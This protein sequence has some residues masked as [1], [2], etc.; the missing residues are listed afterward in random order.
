MSSVNYC[1]FPLFRAASV[2]SVLAGVFFSGETRLSGGQE[3][4][5]DA[6]FFA[7]LD[8]DREGLG[9]VRRAVRSGDH[10]EARAELADYFRNREG[11]FHPIDPRA[12]TKGIANA[13]RKLRAGRLLVDRTGSWDAELWS[14]GEFDWERAEIRFKERMYFFESLAEA[15][16]LEES[17]EIARELVN[18][19]RSFAHRYH[20][21]EERGGGMW[22]TMNVGIR[23]RTG[24]PAA[25]LRLLDSPAFGDDDLILF[26]KSVWDQTDYIRRHPSET[27]NWLTFEM[28]G[29]F[30][31]GVVYPEFK[32]AREWRRIASETAV[33]DMDI[34]WLP[35][36]VSIELSPEY[37]RFFSNFYF[38][39][40][41]AKRTGRLDEFNLREFPPKTE[42]PFAAFL[43]IMAPD[44]LAPAV[45]NN[46]PADVVQILGQ[47]L[48]RFPE[49]D[50]FRWIVTG[51][52]EGERPEFASVLMPHAG[53]AVMRGG[54][55]RGD[56]LLFFDF[57]PVGYRH[58][59]Q[60]GLNVMLWAYGRP[61]LFDPGLG[62]YDYSHPLV[63]Y[64]V[65][66]FS[67]NTV[68][69]DNRPQRRPW[70]DNP[71]PRRMP[72]Q[73]QE[74][75]R[76]ASTETLDVAAGVYDGAYGLPGVSDAYPYSEGSNFREG[77]GHP[78]VHHRRLLFLR[79]DIFVVDDTLVSQDGEAHD[80]DLRWHLNSPRTE[81]TGLAVATRDDGLPN[82]E[83]APLLTD[84]LEVR[85]TSA[86]ME[87]EILGWNAVD[88]LNPRPATTVQHLQSG[89]G[90]VRFLTLLL[91]LPEGR[92]SLLRSHA[93]A[94]DSTHEITLR[95]GRRL[96]LTAPSDPAEDLSAVW[97]D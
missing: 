76:W 12:P 77:W 37:G 4:L 11:V 34:G 90:T 70:Y 1:F 24:W 96:R 36:G 48:E 88:P 49:R 47:G 68:L 3:P 27:S 55:E 46:R 95:D 53:F 44:R 87:P 10:A 41:L 13:D 91:P 31:S 35:D 84:G 45:N 21:P 52:R 63:N 7:K 9:A 40:D 71:H 75:F 26:L 6:E 85:S 38:I 8:L 82:L 18:L 39:Y 23:M 19:M 54:W 43:K 61:L 51:G 2:A 86:Q 66:T 94:G 28:S 92:S 93:A 57:G 97:L 72:Y 30:T 58:A 56:H 73:K 14:G 64:A 80:Y 22:A 29:L 74:N 17:G 79:P 5:T 62:N 60:D 32:D 20:S 83:V 33:H 59:H 81:T 65:D 16:A 89:E 78:A 69:V 15:A 25:F 67:H 42:A 50:D